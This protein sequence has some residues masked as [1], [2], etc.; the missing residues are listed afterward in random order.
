MSRQSTNEHVKI[1]LVYKDSE[2]NFCIE[3]LWAEKAGDYY[4]IVNTPFFAGNIAYG[5]IISVEEDDD[6]LFFDALIAPSGHSTIQ[7]IIHDTNEVKE[8]GEDLIVLGCDWEGSHLAGYIS[9]DVPESVTYS[10]LKKYLEDG[11]LAKRWDFREACLA[12]E[13]K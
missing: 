8:I 5:D 10:P 11:L 9:V 4:K 13:H 6:E 1:H 7:M 12:H 3:S 2:E